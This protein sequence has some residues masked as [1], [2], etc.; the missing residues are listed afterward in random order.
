[1]PDDKFSAKKSSKSFGKYVMALDAS[2][3]PIQTIRTP[4]GRDRPRTEVWSSEPLFGFMPNTTHPRKL[5]AV[6]FCGFRF[7]PKDM[8]K[9]G[10]LMYHTVFSVKWLV[11]PTF[12][13]KG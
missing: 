4:S 2:S 5:S 7:M 3:W 12:S 10:N 1:M 8:Q 9:G 6:L 13:Q 11:L